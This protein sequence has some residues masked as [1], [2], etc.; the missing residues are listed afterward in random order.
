[1]V[2]QQDNTQ[3]A[4]SSSEQETSMAHVFKVLENALAA[5]RAL[6]EASESQR[7]AT[8]K[9]S[10]RESIDLQMLSN[11]IPPVNF[12]PIAPSWQGGKNTN[13]EANKLVAEIG[14][15]AREN[16]PNHSLGDAI[17]AVGGLF[18]RVWTEIDE[19]LHALSTFRRLIENRAPDLFVARPDDSYF[20][21]W[22][23]RRMTGLDTAEFML[24]RW[25]D[26]GG[27]MG[28]VSGQGARP[29]H[30]ITELAMTKHYLRNI[31]ERAENASEV[32]QEGFSEIDAVAWALFESLPEGSKERALASALMELC[33]RVNQAGSSAWEDIA[34]EQPAPESVT[35]GSEEEA[36]DAVAEA[37]HG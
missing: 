14:R 37:S 16:L 3:V 20:I 2:N 22:Q 34:T 32:L 10:F 18:S 35:D 5:A 8:L 30:P 19:S 9:A 24:H 23:G 36:V 27:A 29:A 25:Q 33:N 1:M 28:N 7:E 13:T 6:R 11:A 26:R 4:A 21:A 15:W 31:H 12:T 17:D